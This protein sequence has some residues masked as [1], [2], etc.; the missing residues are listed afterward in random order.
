MTTVALLGA[1]LIVSACGLP[2]SGP[3][4]GEIFS[5]SV[6]KGGFH[7]TGFHPTGLIGIFAA[8]LIA[9]RMRDLT[10]HV[11]GERGGRPLPNGLAVQDWRT[12][13]SHGFSLCTSTS[14]ICPFRA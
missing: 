11:A 8:T 10:V 14:P 13:R 9:G 7:Q 3:T 5:G 2:R 4:K 12:G 6:A 1:A